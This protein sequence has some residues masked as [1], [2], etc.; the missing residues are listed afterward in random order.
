[1]IEF[2]LKLFG[3]WCDPS[4]A[5]EVPEVDVIKK[6]PRTI[7]TNVRFRGGKAFEVSPDG[8]FEERTTVGRTASRTPGDE[9]IL[10]EEPGQG[11]PALKP[12]KYFELKPYWAK[13][14]SAL[15]VAKVFGGKRGYKVRTV[16]HYWAAFFR[17]QALDEKQTLGELH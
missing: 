12:D 2:F 7:P 9:T 11:K 5:M 10:S 13:G 15:E 6:S 3:I 1:M 4:E 16:E 8:K 17:A 14:L